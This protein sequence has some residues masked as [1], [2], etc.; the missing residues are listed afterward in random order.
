M[1]L[2]PGEILVTWDP[3]D[4]VL[5]ARI[6]ERRWNGWVRPAFDR[7]N[8]QKLIDWNKPR[9]D[10]GYAPVVWDGNDVLVGWDLGI[11]RVAP[12][13]DNGVERWA[14]GDGWCWYET[15]VELNA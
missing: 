13:L 12:F 5:V 6:D 10:E 3:D 2:L 7:A 8:V 1:N 15:R 9:E 14:I 11:D 4:I